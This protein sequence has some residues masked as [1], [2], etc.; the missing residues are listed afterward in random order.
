[1]L[2]SEI[3]TYLAISLYYLLASLAVNQNIENRAECSVPI[4]AVASDVRECL[5]HKCAAQDVR[6]ILRHDL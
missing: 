6:G 1:M 2:A 3:K 4:I 5:K